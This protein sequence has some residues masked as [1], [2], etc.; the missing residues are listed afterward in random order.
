MQVTFMMRPQ[1]CFSMALM[2]ACV[3]RKG[4][5]RLVA[6]TSSQS[7][8]FM[9]SSKVVA[10]DAGVVDQNVELAEAGRDLP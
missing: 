2:T 6:I 4:A 1:R 9:R 3:S 8:R 7:A 5:V 10:G